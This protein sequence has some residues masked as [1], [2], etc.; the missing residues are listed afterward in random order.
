MVLQVHMIGN[1]EK[2]AKYCFWI[3]IYVAVYIF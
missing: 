1:V 2:Y 3:E